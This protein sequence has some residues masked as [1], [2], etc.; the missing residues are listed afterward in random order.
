MCTSLEVVS[1]GGRGREDNK[2]LTFKVSTCD[3]FIFYKER[4]RGRASEGRREGGRGWEVR[5]ISTLVK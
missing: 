5:E 4:L 3:Y 2:F 1:G